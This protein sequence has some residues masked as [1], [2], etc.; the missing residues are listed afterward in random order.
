MTALLEAIQVLPAIVQALQDNPTGATVLVCLS[1]L[2][3]A[4]YALHKRG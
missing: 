1:A 2:A 4:A 3:V